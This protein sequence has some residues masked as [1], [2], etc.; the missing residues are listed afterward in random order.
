MKFEREIP[1]GLDAHKKKTTGGGAEKA[2]P[3]PI[4]LAL[5][6]LK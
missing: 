2:P 3:P 4:G 1:I 6:L 5:R